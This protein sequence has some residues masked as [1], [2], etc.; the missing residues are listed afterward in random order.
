MEHETMYPDAYPIARIRL[1]PAE[2]VTAGAGAMVSMS[3]GI[4]I[5]T[6]T[7]GGMLSGLKRRLAGVSFFL[8]TFRANSGGLIDFAPPLPGNITHVALAGGTMFVGSGSYLASSGGI[9]VD[10]QWAGAKGL[11]AKEGLFLIK[12]QGTG[13]LFLSSYGAIHE[14]RLETGESQTIDNGYL[15]AFDEGVTW[16]LRRAGG[17]KSTLF[18]GEGLVCTYSGP[19]RVLMQ[20]RSHHAL[21]AWLRPYM[22]QYQHSSGQSQQ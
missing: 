11:F 9:S 22:Y 4:T 7:G 10:T 15:V 5:E 8:N 6:S 16:K 14:Q 2:S 13:S 18:S 1:S 19:G 20:T 3:E 12:V 17:L 21:I